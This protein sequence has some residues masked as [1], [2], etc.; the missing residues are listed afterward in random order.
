[1]FS[2]RFKCSYTINLS[3]IAEVNKHANAFTSPIFTSP[4]K[5]GKGYTTVIVDGSTEIL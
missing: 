1:M 3:F 2:N 4:E 5:N